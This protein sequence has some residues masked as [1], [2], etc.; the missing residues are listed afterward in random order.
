MRLIYNSRM[1]AVIVLLIATLILSSCNQH[2]MTDDYYETLWAPYVSDTESIITSVENNSN[3]PETGSITEDGSDISISESENDLI[4]Q[5]PGNSK[6]HVMSQDAVTQYI[7]KIKTRNI[8]DITF[9]NSNIDGEGKYSENFS[10]VCHTSSPEYIECIGDEFYTLSWQNTV[11]KVYI[12]V[13][14]YNKQQQ[15]IKWTNIGSTNSKTSSTIKLDKDC[16]YVRIKL[17]SDISSVTWNELI[18]AEFQMELGTSA[19]PYVKPIVIDTSEIDLKQIADVL[20]ENGMIDNVTST[21]Y[22]ATQNSLLKQIAHRGYCATGAPQCTAPAYIEA[23]LAGYAAGENDLWITTDGVFVMAHDVTMPSDKSVIV[24]ES[25]YEALLECNMGTYKGQN[26]DIMTF[27]E[28]LILMKKIGLEAYVDLKSPL[29]SE[30]AIEIMNIVRKHG[31]L[32]KVTWSTNNTE[33]IR[34]LRTAYPYARLAL[35]G[36]TQIN[37][38]VLDLR[39]EGR[40][41]LTV[42]YPQSIKLTDEVIENARNSGIGVECWHVG[43]S[44]YGFDTEEEIFA[45]I[46]RVFELGVTGI[47]L[48]TYLPSEYFLNK[49]LSEWGIE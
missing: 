26:V 4:V 6:D 18:P 22:A 17:W 44:S 15:F 28:W 41:D 12:Y 3:L 46:E 35:L 32:D 31:M 11:L 16:S 24:A 5:E 19:T 30:Q 36:W 7:K 43:Y 48:D 21:K 10:G 29:N 20:V 37:N 8:L 40:P 38:F 39:I 47:C 14:E 23:K 25:T 27:E 45:E 49:L 13:F 33:T 42:L 34:G 2:P 1:I 9:S